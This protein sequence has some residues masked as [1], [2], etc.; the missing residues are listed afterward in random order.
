MFSTTQQDYLQPMVEG[1]YED[2]YTY[3]VAYTNTNLSG[4]SSQDFRDLT[5]IFSK[6][7]I[8]SDNYNFTGTE[9]VRYDVITRSASDRYQGERVSKSSGARFS[10][11]VP[12]YEFISSNADGSDYMNHLALVE[13]Q[14][15]N[16]LSYN[17]DLNDFWSFGVL[18][19][20][21]ILLIWLKSW[22]ARNGGHV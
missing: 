11:T 14:Q 22:F 3:Y 15:K 16:D 10:V 12:V 20:I 21:I 19:S 13:H 8:V 6:N 4:S 7:N 17:L 9:Y 18:I 2:G 5:L 1:M